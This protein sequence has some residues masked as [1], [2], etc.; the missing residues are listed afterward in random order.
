MMLSG[1]FPRQNK[2]IIILGN[3]TTMTL[4]QSL[5]TVAVCHSLFFFFF[6]NLRPVLVA[7][8]MF[9]DQGSNPGPH[10]LGVQILTHC[11][12]REVPAIA[13]ELSMFK[14]LFDGLFKAIRTRKGDKSL[15]PFAFLVAL[16]S[17]TKIQS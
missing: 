15:G 4:D 3:K 2:F 11:T 16:G 5:N 10:A 12:T 17:S 1:Y 8:C 6:L 9:P 7:A 14:N 13:F